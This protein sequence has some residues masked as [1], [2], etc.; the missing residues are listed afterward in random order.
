MICVASIFDNLVQFYK[1][2]AFIQGE[3]FLSYKYFS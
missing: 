1:K 2:L 3:F